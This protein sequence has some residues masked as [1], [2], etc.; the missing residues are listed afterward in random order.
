M[1]RFIKN[2][3]MS[4]VKGQRIGGT[5]IPAGGTVERPS[6]SIEGTTRFNTD[7]DNLEVYNGT[8]FDAIAKEGD[9]TITKDGF[10]GDGSTTAYTLS[11][12]PP[13]ENSILVFVGN[14]F[15]NP[16]VAFTLSGATITFSSAP[17]LSHTIVVLHG[18]N[19][20]VVS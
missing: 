4:S 12:T 5:N 9:V 8:G 2:S 16:G 10:T 6:D 3:I 11:V 7:T 1:G 20:T 18:F 19:S 13:S 15:Q 17:P 14:V